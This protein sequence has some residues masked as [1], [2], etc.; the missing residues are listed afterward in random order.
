MPPIV[1]VDTDTN[2]GSSPDAAAILGAGGGSQQPAQP[3][4]ANAPLNTRQAPVAPPVQG[5]ASPAQLAPADQKAHTLGRVIQHFTHA[6]EGKQTVYTPDPSTGTV[7][8]QVV[9]RKAGGFFRDLLAGALSGMA[10]ASEP[11]AHP[12]GAAGLGLGFQGAASAMQS[13]QDRA[14]NMAA[15]QA[16]NQYVKKQRVDADQAAAAANAQ[17]TLSTLQLGHNIA[18]HSDSEIDQHNTSVDTLRSILDKNGAQLANVQNNNV[19]GN[20]PALMAAYNSD[21]TLME[22]P[23]G[24]HRVVTISYDTADLK[25]ENGKWVNADGSPLD[26]AAWNQR[27]TVSLVDVPTAMWAK[28]VTLPG[29]AIQDL[30]PNVQG[31]VQDPK[32]DYST[33]V[34]SL[35]ALNLKDKKAMHDAREEMYRPPKDENEALGMQATAQRILDNPDQATADER[36]WAA[37]KAPIAQKWLEGQAAQKKAMDEAGPQKP[38]PVIDTAGKAQAA[39]NAARIALRANPSDPALKQAYQDAQDNRDNLLEMENKQKKIQTQQDTIARTQAEGKDVESM[40]KNGTNPITKEKLSLDN[41]PDEFLVDQ[42]TGNPIPSSMLTTVKP[43]MQEIN[44]HDFAGSV[45]H[46]LDQID[47]LQA[48]GKLPNGPLSGLTQQKLSKAGLST[49][50]AQEALNFISFAQSA[51]TGAH[52]GGRFSLPVMQKMN[53][54][55]G[56]NMNSNEFKGAEESMRD[57]MDQYYK[58]GGRM[59]VA[60]YKSLPANDPVRQAGAGSPSPANRQQQAPAN[61][62]PLQS[63]YVRFKDSQGGVHDIPKANLGAAQQRDKGLTVLQGQ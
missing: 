53:G 5:P 22:G 57:V 36:R 1:P 20:G 38:G 16:A 17:N 56:L 19:K 27:A 26:D 3:T 55:I 13:Q 11:T 18:L 62:P 35:F 49:E 10:A 15:D 14:R 31:L 21:P 23:D 39:V 54:M 60:E 58:N 59:T 12:S 34:G 46:S 33:S 32:K 42:R 7:Q 50:D 25:H 40:Y 28:K 47:K 45:L 8:A 41:A 29:S 4:L 43:T 37:V 63:G 44:R 6:L 61:M 2:T 30:A 51:A 48:A 9:P 52:V 24:T